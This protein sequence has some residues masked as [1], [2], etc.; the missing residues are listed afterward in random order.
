MHKHG[1]RPYFVQLL[2]AAGF[3]GTLVLRIPNIFFVTWVMSYFA[4]YDCVVG[5][6]YKIPTENEM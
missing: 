4:H 2:L 5:Y 1:E 3:Y 6:T